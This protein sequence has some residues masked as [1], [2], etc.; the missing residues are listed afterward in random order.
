MIKSSWMSQTPIE[1]QK[2]TNPWKDSTLTYFER[3]SIMIV[4]LTYIFESK[5]H[6][7]EKGYLWYG[8]TSC[9][10]L[11]SS[12]WALWDVY[13]SQCK[14]SCNRHKTSD[15]WTFCIS[16]VL[17]E[18]SLFLLVRGIWDMPNSLKYDFMSW[19]AWFCRYEIIFQVLTD[20]HIFKCKML[21]ILTNTLGM[22]RRRALLFFD[23]RSQNRVRKVFFRCCPKASTLYTVW[24]FFV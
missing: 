4:S 3:K 5:A 9:Y 17:Q 2:N 12:S 21:W 18:C 13:P 7:P 16:V 19:R 14:A 6:E 11:E 10:C 24:A 22:W 8:S 1:C 23:S 15:S 20:W